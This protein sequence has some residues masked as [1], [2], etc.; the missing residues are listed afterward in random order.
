MP[1]WLLSLAGILLTA[2][3]AFLA[4]RHVGEQRREPIAQPP[5]ASA[6][7]RWVKSDFFRPRPEQVLEAQWEICDQADD[8][9]P[10]HS[11]HIKEGDKVL[12]EFGPA[13]EI[14]E[15]RELDLDR[16]GNEELLVVEQSAG[17]G[18]YLTWCLFGQTPAGLGCWQVPGLDAV[19]KQQLQGEEHTCCKDWTLKVR[20]GRLEVGR[21]IYAKNDGNCCPSRGGLFV[22]LV[23]DHGRLRAA[24][25]RRASVA[26]YKAWLWTP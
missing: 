3:A 6:R 8:E 24:N 14:A 2:T 22:D 4:G 9:R 19:G 7:C 18:N 15:L 13:D 11:I 17:T 16:D 5:R 1:R 10:L 25:V 12:K 23:P 21:G 20:N 26:D